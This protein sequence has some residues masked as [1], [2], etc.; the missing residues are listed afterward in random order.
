MADFSDFSLGKKNNKIKINTQSIKGGIKSSALSDEKLTIFKNNIDTD[1][2][3]IFNKE[4]IDKFIEQIKLY[5]EDNNLSV[6][7]AAKYLKSNKLENVKPEDLFYFLKVLE[8][9][10]ENILESNVITCNDG[11]KTIYIKY[12][13]SSEEIIYPDK[14]SKYVKTGEN[15]ENTA[16]LKDSEG[17][18]LNEKVALSDKTLIFTEYENGLP[19]LKTIK[20]PDGTIAEITFE[21]GS[22]KSKTEKRGEELL[23]YIYVNEREY[24]TYSKEYKNN[25]WVETNIQYDENGRI[26]ATERKAE[27]ENQRFSVDRENFKYHDNGQLAQKTVTSGHGSDIE[28]HEDIVTVTYDENGKR[29]TMSNRNSYRTEKQSNEQE[30][31]H[32]S[33]DDNGNIVGYVPIGYTPDMIISELKISEDSE[34]YDKFFELN[35]EKIKQFNG[36]KFSGF[37]VGEKIIIPGEVEDSALTFI[38]TNPKHEKSV[39][40]AENLW[41]ANI[42]LMPTGDK[43][44]EKDMSWWDIARQN[45]I[46]LGYNNPTNSQIAKNFDALITLNG[47][48]G[49]LLNKPVKKGSIIRVQAK[50]SDKLKDIYKIE[51]YGIEQL[52]KKYPSD[53]YQIKKIDKPTIDEEGYSS[54]TDGEYRVYDKATNKPILSVVQYEKREGVDT[55]VVR[56]YR[57]GKVYEEIVFPKFGN[58]FYSTIYGKDN[59]IKTTYNINGDKIKV[60]VTNKRTPIKQ[61]ITYPNNSTKRVEIFNGNTKEK[62]LIYRNGE[63]YQRVFKNRVD[64]FDKTGKVYCIVKEDEYKDLDITY[65]AT[66][67]FLKALKKGDSE[68]LTNIISN[69]DNDNCKLFLMAYESKIGRGVMSDIKRSNLDKTTQNRLLSKLKSLLDKEY[70]ITKTKR[71]SQLSNSTEGDAYDINYDGKFLSVKNRKTGKLTRIDLNKKL[72]NCTELERI[73]LTKYMVENLPGEVLEDFAIEVPSMGFAPI[74]YMM[75]SDTEAAGIYKEFNDNIEISRCEIYNMVNPPR[76]LFYDIDIKMEGVVSSLL[77]TIAHELGHAVDF[78]GYSVNNSSSEAS[79]KFKKVFEKEL[80]KYISSGHVQF[81]STPDF[82]PYTVIRWPD[83]STDNI[84]AYATS[85]IGE[86]FAECYTLLMLGNC[87]SAKHIKKYFPETLNAAEVLLKEIRSKS[88][89]ER[90]NSFHGA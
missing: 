81:G 32:I 43:T 1:G 21:N 7:E 68:T 31:Y 66:Q 12:K 57:E 83:G 29:L 13:D 84:S 17:N 86:M 53:K 15:G 64:Y 2:D 47:V 56:H 22:L 3:N 72:S 60:E 23:K 88:E 48:P 75:D 34:L 51:N 67:N 78:N 50:S 61:V 42:Q 55:P 82:N 49:F 69:L 27:C 63:L 39:Y 20:S 45:L 38:K 24:L 37:T 87:T 44:L 19:V 25:K 85:S 41:N 11:L 62:V 52:K 16:I 14:T 71:T 73:I 90:Y 89:S 65:P 40:A 80:E 33:F 18:I 59:E 36:G 58:E 79:L 35:R 28:Y 10:S 77:T 26:S 46:D 76:Y 54:G 6:R 5:A 30:I 9:A 4:E 8:Q 74:Q 70:K